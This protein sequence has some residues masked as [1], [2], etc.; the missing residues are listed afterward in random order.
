MYPPWHSSLKIYPRYAGNKRRKEYTEYILRESLTLGILKINAK[1]NV[2][3]EKVLPEKRT[4]S[5]LYTIIMY[6]SVILPI[7]DLV[8]Y[9]MDETILRESLSTRSW[10]I[11]IYSLMRES[12]LTQTLNRWHNISA[13]GVVAHL[14]SNL[15]VS[16]RR[17]MVG[18]NNIQFLCLPTLP[19]G[20]LEPITHQNHEESL[21][22]QGPDHYYQ[23]IDHEFTEPAPK[24]RWIKDNTDIWVREL[25]PRPYVPLAINWFRR[26]ADICFGGQADM[27]ECKFTLNFLEENRRKLTRKKY[28]VYK[29]SPKSPWI[30]IECGNRHYYRDMKTR[31]K[32]R[33]EPSQGFS[34]VNI[35]D[36]YYFD[37]EYPILYQNN[38]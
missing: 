12:K 26:S 8:R 19:R 27:W 10:Y 31:R 16:A 14:D 38:S 34:N 20:C 23:I 18:S 25:A 9:V 35:A 29:F 17:K 22:S 7:P 15:S 3:I 32:K 6:L 30:R 13:E 4:P 2:I 11:S 1:E 37:R 5:D 36:I 24:I 21:Y 28:G 33:S